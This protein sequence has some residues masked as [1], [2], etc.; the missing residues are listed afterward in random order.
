M[1]KGGGVGGISPGHVGYSYQP[2]QVTA[3][4]NVEHAKQ[5]GHIVTVVNNPNS[6]LPSGP[7]L[8]GKAPL[9][10]S[11]DIQATKHYDNE[12]K[13]WEKIALCIELE[14]HELEAFQKMQPDQR[15]ELLGAFRSSLSRDDWQCLMHTKNP[16]EVQQVLGSDMVDTDLSGPQAGFQ[17]ST[18]AI[19]EGAG[20][21]LNYEN[22]FNKLARGE[23]LT[24]EERAAFQNMDPKTKAAWKA[25]LQDDFK[26]NGI[27]VKSGDLDNL[28]NGGSA[29]LALP[30]FSGSVPGV[31]GS[32]PSVN[33]SLPSVNG[34]LPNVSGSL[35]NV[36]G[37]LPGGNFSTPDF[38]LSGDSGKYKALKNKDK[39]WEKVRSGKQLNFLERRRLRKLPNEHQLGLQKE[40]NI[41]NDQWR[42]LVRNG[43]LDGAPAGNQVGFGGGGFG[44]NLSTPDLRGGVGGGDLDGGFGGQSGNFGISTGQGQIPGGQAGIGGGEFGGRVNPPNFNGGL[45]GFELDSDSDS[46]GLGAGINT[47]NVGGSVGGPGFKAGVT[48]PSVGLDANAG[49]V[50][51]AGRMRRFGRKLYNFFIGKPITKFVKWGS[52]F[53]IKH[54]SR[55][56]DKNKD[57]LYQASAHLSG[58]PPRGQEGNA[59]ISHDQMANT[60]MCMNQPGSVI[61]DMS[62][63]HP[64]ARKQF[65]PEVLDQLGTSRLYQE[66]V[67]AHN[68][69]VSI[70]TGQSTDQGQ[71][72]GSLGYELP[73]VKFSGQTGAPDGAG[74]NSKTGDVFDQVGM[75]QGNTTSAPNQSGVSVNAGLD[76]PDVSGEVTPRLGIIERTK[77]TL[78]NGASTIK[79][80]FSRKGKTD[81]N[82]AGV[83]GGIG[84]NGQP[85]S[86]TTTSSIGVQTI[87]NPPVTNTQ[88]TPLHPTKTFA[89]AGIVLDGSNVRGSKDTMNLY[90]YLAGLER[91]EGTSQE[92]L[93]SNIQESMMFCGLAR[94]EGNE[95]V[96]LPHT[97]HQASM[98]C[99][100]VNFG[101]EDRENQAHMM[102][103]A[104]QSRQQLPP[105]PPP[106]RNPP[107][108]GRKNDTA[109]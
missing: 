78:S 30:S 82:G 87:Q 61:A 53:G 106:Y 81:T 95:L 31:S 86:G 9:K 101:I 48:P 40:W 93:E 8:E 21:G 25:Q 62:M 71:R 64:E 16:E 63:Y 41:S 65:S 44:T 98:A 17:V 1:G 13:A 102:Q 54:M 74:I 14:P 51:K 10:T 56:D 60:M 22:I 2:D 88:F 104:M 23:S 52:K 109:V 97:L 33:G 36:S 37:S 20:S 39:T 96:L 80:A 83:S 79:G 94:Q 28:F 107:T 70:G 55:W 73:N 26:Q 24:P 11:Y 35:P 29:R 91:P 46:S 49:Q 3:R 50:K 99:G 18:G 12:L 66:K 32:L 4:K 105:S 38:G 15:Q 59:V 77:Q 47:P 6:Q 43:K 5:N 27:N 19:G 76:T 42:G 67:Q 68:G 100:W 7:R 45:G 57:N 90:R 69:N 58:L 103:K 84:V 85:P 75:G 72:S 92:D 108:Y 34:S 89:A